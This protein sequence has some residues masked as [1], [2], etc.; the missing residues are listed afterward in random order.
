MLK[1]TMKIVSRRRQAGDI[2]V[3]LMIALIVLAVMAGAAYVWYS[4]TSKQQATKDAAAK[5]NYIAGKLQSQFG[6][7]ND[8]PNITTAVAVQSRAIPP[9]MRVSGANTAVNMFGGTV[10]VAPSNCSATNDC[11]AMTWT[12]VPADNCTDLVLMTAKMAR[13]ITVAGTA[14]KVLD[15]AMPSAT[16][17]GKCDAAAPVTI[18]WDYGRSAT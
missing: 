12:N 4:D 18:V 16:L 7:N 14:V 2:L 13:R 17:T 1:K 8:Y 15:G 6:V 5:I 3:T 9:D 11:A 10:S